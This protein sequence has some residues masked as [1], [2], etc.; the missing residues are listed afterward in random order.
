VNGTVLFKTFT[1]FVTG[2]TL[3]S[4]TVSHLWLKIL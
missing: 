1:E 4:V 3:V 2:S